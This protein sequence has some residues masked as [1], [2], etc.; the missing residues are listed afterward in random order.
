MNESELGQSILNFIARAEYRPMKPRAIAKHLRVPEEQIADMKR[1]VKRLVRRGQLRYG[2][3]HLVMAA[4]ADYKRGQSHFCR[5]C[6]HGARKIGQS[7]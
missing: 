1:V 3:N 7:R 6:K 2:S 4:E 5:P